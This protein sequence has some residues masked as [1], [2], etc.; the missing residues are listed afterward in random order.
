LTSSVTD[1][2]TAEAPAEPLDAPLNQQ[3]TELKPPRGWQALHLTELWRYRELLFI[4][5]MRDV[6]VRYKQTVLGAGW[7]VIQPLLQMVIF[8]VIFSYFAGMKADNGIPYSAFTLVA[9]LPWQLFASGVAN[10]GT[11]LISA[12]NLISKV[13][14]PRLVVPF[15]A[16]ISALV[17]FGVAF[18]IFLGM[19]LW[20]RVPLTAAVLAFPFFLL[21]AILSALAFSIWFA[22]LNVKYRDF[23]VVIPF[24][25][26]LGSYASPVG[27]SSTLAHH[28]L[29]GL[30]WIY[31]LNP[32]VAVIEGFRWCF[33]SGYVAPA[34]AMSGTNPATATAPV[35]LVNPFQSE[36]LYIS[37]GIVAVLFI[38]GLFYFKRVEK[39]FADVI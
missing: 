18:V 14:F 12:Q 26:Q 22:S 19:M 30:Y 25:I 21:L 27:Y 5:G 7:A 32:M 34:S 36:S 6:K 4:L 9:L 10:G 20:Y 23:R 2:A 15:A 37:M 38:T 35:A 1:M 33:F 28:K 17:D 16:I 29:G 24:F 13:Y 39:S 3:I 31:T 11:S 8:T